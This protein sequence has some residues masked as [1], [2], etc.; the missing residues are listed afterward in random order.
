MSLI[1]IKSGTRAQIDAAAALNG[2]NAK[3][4]YFISDEGIMSLGIS[5]G[6]YIDLVKTQASV[7]AGNILTVG[8]KGQL[9]DTGY[10]IDDLGSGAT[11]IWT[12]DKVNTLIAAIN[13]VP[14]TRTVNGHALTSDVSVTAG[15]VGLGNVTNE[16]K[17]TMFTDPTFT[18]TVT[19]VTAEMVGLG[20]A[21]NES[22]ATMFT[23][24]TF[25][26][27][28]TGVTAA[29]TGAVPMTMIDDDTSLTLGTNLP[30]QAAVKAYINTVM[31]A[32]A[33]MAFIGVID[34][35]ANPDYPAAYIGNTWRASVAGRIGGASGPAVE[36][37][38][39]ILAVADSAGG[40]HATVGA[41]FSIIQTNIDGAVVG[42]ASATN[43]TIAVFDGLSG[44][45]IKGSTLKVADLVEKTTTINGHD[46]TANVSITA[47]DI[48]LGNVSNVKA[49]AASQL[50]TTTTLGT[51][52]TL[53][54]SQNAVKT[55]VDT[56][57]GVIDGGT[58]A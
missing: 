27:T 6:T 58:F 40:T 18:G 19:G 31:T 2:L 30:T 47:A 42:P 39:I 38:D 9:A 28:V 10:K 23:D 35:S 8:A 52:D 46:L 29:M 12:A 11:T 32:N 50:S 4:P 34:C 54:P 37:G 51:S 48:G 49:I 57:A 55:Y 20:N 14:D 3:E 13:F 21:T 33:T 17:A 56:V 26:G 22:K 25:T 7:T 36:A 43:E 41:S 44:K 24:P 15:D 5:A 16:S 45:L 1:T 53:V